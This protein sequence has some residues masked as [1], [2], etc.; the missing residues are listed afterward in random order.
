MKRK[1]RVKTKLRETWRQI[2]DRKDREMY[3]LWRTLPP[4][5]TQA[6]AGDK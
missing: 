6:L 1:D 2:Q 4:P 5:K 3:D